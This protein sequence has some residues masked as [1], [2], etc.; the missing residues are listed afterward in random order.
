MSVPAMAYWNTLLFEKFESSADNWPWARG[1]GEWML[2][3]NRPYLWWVERNTYFHEGSPND[4]QSLWCCGFP[5]D[6]QP[7]FHA[8]AANQ[9]NFAV[10]GPF[11]LS[12]AIAAGG[13]FWGFFDLEANTNGT[14]DDFYFVIIDEEP[15]TDIDD[16]DY[17]Y[18]R[19]TG[20]LNYEW[21][22]ITLDFDE[23]YTHDG[24]TISYLG[25][26]EVYIGLYFHSDADN[27]RGFG[28]FIDDVAIGYDDGEFDF[29]MGD[30][31]VEDP[32]DPDHEYNY[33][34]VN[35]PVR[36]RGRFVAHGDLTSEIVDHILY[37]NDE[38]IDT[39]TA[40]WQGS[41]FGEAYNVLFEEVYTPLDT[42]YVDF[43][44]V[45]DVQDQQVE[46]FE[47][48]NAFEQNFQILPENH[49]PWLIF[50]NPSEGGVTTPAGV[51]NIIYEAY[52]T[53]ESETA[54]ISFLYDNV[55]EG[56][57]GSPIPNALS[58]PIT[59]VRDTI[60]WNMSYLPDDEYFI[61]AYLD[62]NFW[63]PVFQYAPPI[64][65]DVEEGQNGQLPDAFRLVS[66]H[67][68]PFNPTVELTMELPLNS[69]V[70][71]FWYSIDGRQVDS[72][73]FG[74]LNAGTRRVQWTPNNLPSGVYL[75]KVESSFGTV[76]G[77]VT[78]IK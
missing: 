22:N 26:E 34:F 15:T 21:E 66:L 49:Q 46:K 43:K 2:G 72:Q 14:G 40:A 27:E 48:N 29:E 63:E 58:L 65:L 39:V 33:L 20:T 24:D 61:F 23:V 71:T 10:W 32:D 64:M 1:E 75:V 7:G 5:N 11:D 78:F 57:S 30:L 19:R 13:N 18:Q 54:T 70:N 56:F 50:I 67:P 52:N 74:I 17:L 53:P 42:G 8:Y 4:V 41:R 12:T 38:P 31:R 73:N 47:D 45:L 59:N 69:V 62:D 36:I 68:N 60:V 37:V 76:N 77:R 3:P 35:Q 16:Y 44:I 55:G 51:F 6:M 28:V 25:R 9:D